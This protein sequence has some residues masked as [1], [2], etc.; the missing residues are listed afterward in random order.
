MAVPW[1]QACHAIDACQWCGTVHVICH[2][3]ALKRLYLKFSGEYAQCPGPAC[4]WGVRCGSQ[5][6]EHQNCVQAGERMDRLRDE[7]MHYEGCSSHHVERQE[8]LQQLRRVGISDEAALRELARVPPLPF[9]PCYVRP[10][11]F[12]DTIGGHVQ[13]AEWCA[14]PP[15]PPSRTRHL[16]CTAATQ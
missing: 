4:A 8:A 6:S 2:S 1:G 9:D 5:V 10:A 16:W 3:C 14:P 7:L 12:A 15:L 13:H 11:V